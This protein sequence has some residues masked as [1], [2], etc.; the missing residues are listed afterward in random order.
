M[1]WRCLHFCSRCHRTKQEARQNTITVLPDWCMNAYC[2]PTDR[3]QPGHTSECCMA[4]LLLPTREVAKR[5]LAVVGFYCLSVATAVTTGTT[6][7]NPSR[8][9]DIEHALRA[10]TKLF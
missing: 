1:V 6:P 2:V 3:P 7:E 9:L 10:D 4:R 8:V 5:H